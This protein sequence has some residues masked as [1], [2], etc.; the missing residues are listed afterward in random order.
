MLHQL[1]E[2]WNDY[3]LSDK[4]Y[5]RAKSITRGKYD[6]FII[7]KGVNYQEAIKS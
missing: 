3:I 5:F 2:I 1:K 4:V 7:K 6:H